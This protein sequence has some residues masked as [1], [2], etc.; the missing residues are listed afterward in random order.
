LVALQ[1]VGTADSADH[2][3]AAVGA[4][5]LFA[6]GVE[7]KSHPLIAAAQAVPSR[8]RS[9]VAGEVEDVVAA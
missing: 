5:T 9:V 2:A 6:G 8:R 7:R 4:S 1:L 3:V